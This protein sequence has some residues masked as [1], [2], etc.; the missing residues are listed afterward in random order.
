MV[1][2]CSKN[3]L[4]RLVSVL[5]HFHIT[6]EGKV[7]M[8]LPAMLLPRRRSHAYVYLRVHAYGARLYKHVLKVSDHVL[9]CYK[10]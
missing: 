1:Y 4:I 3:Y 5:R 8:L 9:I 10:S 2:E 7:L 6:C